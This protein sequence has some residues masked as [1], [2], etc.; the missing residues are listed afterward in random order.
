MTSRKLSDSLTVSD[1]PRYSSIFVALLV[2]VAI[3]AAC[4]QQ[5]TGQKNG[6]EVKTSNSS[7]EPTATDDVDLMRDED[8]A[9]RPIIISGGSVNLF[10]NRQHYR[11]ESSPDNAKIFRGRNFHIRTIELFNDSEAAGGTRLCHPQLQDACA[12]GGCRVVLQYDLGGSPGTVTIDSFNA[13]GNERIDI[14][15][16]TTKLLRRLKK[17]NNSAGGAVITGLGFSTS[18]G[19]GPLTP[20]SGVNSM[21]TL[22]I[23]TIE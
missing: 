11:P 7:P 15:F 12:D 16:D 23:D 5:P 17:K 6:T 10:F 13:V 20:C 4:D 22:E 8:D 18:A 19:S 2:V 21:A 14:T 3:S 9:E 1:R